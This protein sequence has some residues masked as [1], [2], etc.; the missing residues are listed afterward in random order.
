MTAHTCTPAGEDDPERGNSLV[1][2]D[3]LLTSLEAIQTSLVPPA[4]FDEE[5]ADLERAY[6]ELCLTVAEQLA[7]EEK[8]QLNAGVVYSALSP[9]STQMLKPERGGIGI[10]NLP[11]SPTALVTKRHRYQQTEYRIGEATR[12]A[13]ST[14]PKWD[15]QI[16]GLAKAASEAV[17]TGSAGKLAAGYTTAEHTIAARG[18]SEPSGT[19]EGDMATEQ[20]RGPDQGS[21]S[22]DTGPETDGSSGDRHNGT[23]RM[24][25]P[26]RKPGRNTPRAGGPPPGRDPQAAPP[27]HRPG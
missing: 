21:P 19:A 10:T 15:G 7:P 1:D 26:P 12:K 13:H 11:D 17:Q 23:T 27:G 18:A 3:R 22:L 6:L 5:L 4:D 2:L 20:N 24:T 16:A 9:F 25:S 8:G 14:L